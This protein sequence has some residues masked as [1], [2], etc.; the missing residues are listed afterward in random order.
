MHKNVSKHLRGLKLHHLWRH[1]WHA[2]KLHAFLAHR[3]F[4]ISKCPK[5]SPIKE[6]D[7]STALSGF[8]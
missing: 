1:F 4:L 2:K 5:N 8:L 6:S 7:W 3:K